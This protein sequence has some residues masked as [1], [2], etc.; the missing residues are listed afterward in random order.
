MPTTT[1]PERLT[2]S[3]LDGLRAKALPPVIRRMDDV[4]GEIASLPGQHAT[5]R[6]G[7]L[8]RAYLVG[9]EDM[10]TERKELVD[11]LAALVECPDYRGINTHEMTAARALLFKHQA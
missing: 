3:T 7:D 11:A 2:H 8:E 5:F 6:G 1:Q 9:R 4:V 10:E